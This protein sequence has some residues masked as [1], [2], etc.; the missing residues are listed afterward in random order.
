MGDADAEFGSFQKHTT[1]FGLKY[2]SKFGFRGRLGKKEDGRVNP[3]KA[4]PVSTS[5]QGL[6]VVET[7]KDEEE[8]PIEE[9]KADLIQSVEAKRERIDILPE[10]QHNLDLVAELAAI[11]IQ[12][13]IE[14]QDRRKAKLR[15]F[16]ERKT[17]LETSLANKTETILRLE[18]LKEMLSRFLEDPSSLKSDSI[19]NS[20]YTLQSRFP[21]EWIQYDL[22]CLSS[23]YGFEALRKELDVLNQ[24]QLLDFIHQILAKWKKVLQGRVIRN[25][26]VDLY[27]R[28]FFEVIIPCA[29]KYIPDCSDPVASQVL[30][31]IL[32]KVEDFSIEDS[33]IVHVYYLKNLVIPYL[34]GAIETWN[35]STGIF[36]DHVV[37][38]WLPILEFSDDESSRSLIRPLYRSIRVKLQKILEK[39]NASDVSAIEAIQPWS[40]ILSET[41]FHKILDSSIL[42]KLEDHLFDFEINPSSQTLTSIQAIAAWKSVLNPNVLNQMLLHFFFPKWF[43]ALYSWIQMNPDI[44][45]LRQW[46]LGWRQCIEQ[47][48]GLDVPVRVQFLR[49]LQTI[50]RFLREGT[51]SE[52]WIE[53]VI[54]AIEG[55]LKSKISISDEERDDIGIVKMVEMIANRH[56]VLFIPDERSGR[57][58]G[59]Q[60]YTFGNGNVYF[61]KELIRYCPSSSPGQW[62]SLTLSELKKLALNA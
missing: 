50:E 25:Q 43:L 30:L 35:P 22:D 45:Q 56:G 31:E 38:P 61:D 42:P 3:V 39:W 29:S 49:G 24:T 55:G 34:S 32:E 21:G 4:K 33:H 46:Y 27:Q 28:L 19:L 59:K 20:V 18:C 47:L 52:S 60:V 40:G 6:G 10:L 57:I 8:L 15:G 12:N 48:F 41:D 58:S 23:V 14:D 2:L 9:E 62:R 51:I 13:K 5:R 54:T 7:H 17:A 37:H 1:G 16:L 26:K 36:L 11:R 53:F 44:S